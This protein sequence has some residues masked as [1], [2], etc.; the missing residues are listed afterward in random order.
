MLRSEEDCLH[1]ECGVCAIIGCDDAR[2]LCF[3]GLH[4]LQHRGQESFGVVCLENEINSF[5]SNSPVCACFDALSDV[6][7]LNALG[8]VRYSTSGNGSC[9]KQP[10]II[11]VENEKI[12]FA[13]NGNIRNANALRNDLISQGAIIQSTIDTELFVKLI[14]TSKEESLLKKLIDISKKVKG[15]Y[16]CVVMTNEYMIAFRDA[17][18]IRPLSIG[19]C[20]DGY[21]V[22]SE[23]CAFASMGVEFVRD[24]K[25][26]EFAILRPG[27]DIES[28]VPDPGHSRFCVFEYIYFSRPDSMIDEISVYKARKRIG[29]QLAI[30]SS[31][32]ADIV[33]PVPESGVVSAMGY[34]E[35]SN[36]PLEMGITKNPYIGRTFI[37]STQKMRNMGVKLKHSANKEI[38]S[39]NRVILIDDSIVRGT[40][41]QKII[42]EIWAAGA[43]EIHICI[44]SPP[45]KYPCFYGVDTPC[46][47]KLMAANYNVERMRE[48]FQVN[49][50]TFIS[51][52]GLYRAIKNYDRNDMMP[53]FCDA[54][55]TGDYVV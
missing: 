4:H 39:G 5:Y 11:N 37:Q 38:I 44:A 31:I 46:K 30:E 32:D 22:I 45:T 49:S 40:T 7:A 16:S 20:D 26:G 51:I 6:D 9:Y 13:Y 12:V 29:Q 43:K 17:H 15:G 18:G 53:Q 34:A 3:L 23:T 21:I 1:E 28:I 33:V 55:F 8:H 54:C 36:I 27:C 35:Q 2:H 14:Q 25:P 42:K 19:K 24:V 48:I 50:L 10:S 52:N 47:E 41:A